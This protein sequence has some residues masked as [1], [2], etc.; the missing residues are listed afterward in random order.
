MQTVS[1]CKPKSVHDLA[2]R[3]KSDV[4]TLRFQAITSARNALLALRQAV[5]AAISDVRRA[6]A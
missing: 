3:T 6:T 4:H 2:E 1:N 5:N